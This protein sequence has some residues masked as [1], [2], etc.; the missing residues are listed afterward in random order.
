[1][2]PQRRMSVL[3]DGFT[4]IEV[5]M[6]AFII[7]LGVL[8]L[9]A[10]FAGAARQQQ[11]ASQTTS[12]VVVSN[13]A[14]AI[15]ARNFGAIQGSGLPSAPEE[16]WLPVPTPD[17]ANGT[18]LSQDNFLSIDAADNGDTDGSLYF[19]VSENQPTTLIEAVQSQNLDSIY[20]FTPNQMDNPAQ[21]PQGVSAARPLAHGRLDP[22]STTDIRVVLGPVND[23]AQ[24][25]EV[26]QSYSYVNGNDIQS[27]LNSGDITPSIDQATAISDWG[28]LAIANADDERI[29][30]FFPEGIV[31]YSNYIVM[32]VGLGS[33]TGAALYQNPAPAKLR[34]L[35]VATARDVPGLQIRRVEMGPYKWRNDRLISLEDRI[36]S[37]EDASSATGRRPD[38]GYALLYRRFNT[39][40]AQLGIFTY[41]LTPVDGTA[42]RPSTP[43]KAGEPLFVPKERL[44]DIDR[45]DAP[46]R[47]VD[48]ARLNYDTTDKV[49]YLS[50]NPQGSNAVDSRWIT[51]PG[52]LLVVGSFDE[53][54]SAS[55]PNSGADL[56]VR[57]LRKV[58]VSP[59]EVR[60][61]LD[62]VPRSRGKSM[63][64]PAETGSP[65]ATVTVWAVQET[66]KSRRGNATW[67]LSPLDFRVIQVR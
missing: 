60:G 46:I 25:R 27:Y 26:V 52:Q 20:R 47:K 24:V 51:E 54:N 66:V 1:M 55:T 2:S 44:Q 34:V 38:I 14:E 28:T 67:K 22:Q 33:G 43:V 36:V 40:A 45:D 58:T 9:S 16:E 53:D 10:L 15:V 37:K 17:S 62:R 21:M 35:A 29:I 65:N 64:P 32:D 39:G 7:A 3:R 13:N 5:L 49:Y 4:L 48:G 30:R 63:L 59:T 57:V 11:V 6:A 42:L 41:Q 12:A 8:G 50:V 56:P 23:T 31:N 61:Y 19:L 18:N